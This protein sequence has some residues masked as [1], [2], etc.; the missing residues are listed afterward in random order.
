[1]EKIM[2]LKILQSSPHARLPDTRGR[3]NRGRNF[4]GAISRNDSLALSRH[5][6]LTLALQLWVLASQSWG[7]AIPIPAFNV[8]FWEVPLK[9]GWM[10]S[11]NTLLCFIIVHN[12]WDIDLFDIN[13]YVENRINLEH[14]FVGL[15][16]V[17]IKKCTTKYHVTTKLTDKAF[18]WGLNLVHSRLI[19]TENGKYA[20]M[21]KKIP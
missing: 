5:L 3:D 13:I 7:R 18:W 11:P 2:K 8:K 21:W 17:Q 19:E 14:V 1:M 20:S 15:P 6:R 9:E 16:Q 10:Q 12:Q 4:P